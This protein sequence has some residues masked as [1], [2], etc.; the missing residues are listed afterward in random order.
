MKTWTYSWI[1]YPFIFSVAYFISIFNQKIR[2]TLRLRSWK[3]YLSLRL[4]VGNAIEY[5]IHVASQGELEYAIPIIEELSKLNKKVLVTYYSISAKESVEKLSSQFSNV[6]LVVPLPHD[7]LGLMKDFVKLLKNQGV[8]N[9]LLMKYE[10]WPGMLWEC[11]ANKVKVWLVNALKPSWFHS[12]L[13]HKLH[14]ILTGYQSEVANIHHSKILV[15]GD[16]R[17]LRVKR[18]VESS[19]IKLIYPNLFKILNKNKSIV[20]GSMW[21]EDTKVTLEALKNIKININVIWIPHEINND[22]E[23]E[24]TKKIFIEAGFNTQILEQDIESNNLS[25]H[26]NA[27]IINKKGFLSEIYGISKLAYVGGAFGKCVHSVWEPVINECFVACGPNIKRS[28]ESFELQ[29][30]GLLTTIEN[31]EHFL[32]WLSS[33]FDEKL[34]FNKNTLN[35]IMNIHL[36][37]PKKIVEYINKDSENYG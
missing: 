20:L 33:H 11:N 2:R 13:I 27:I 19:Q 25:N 36:E 4:N 21:P 18:R 37:A 28:P 5:W 3:T 31:S 23:I 17:V 24:K 22:N 9:L 14:G 29:K 10:L 15:T 8:Q 26:K 6:S 7:G 16:T 35:N 1:I 12:K 30:I 32:S 34:E